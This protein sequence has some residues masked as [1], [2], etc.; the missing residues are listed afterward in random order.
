MSF[1]S[2]LIRGGFKLVILLIG[3]LWVVTLPEPDPDTLLHYRNAVAVLGAL[4]TAGKI[5]CDTLFYDRY[6]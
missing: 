2:R 4:I 3:T 1:Q 5:V 6:A